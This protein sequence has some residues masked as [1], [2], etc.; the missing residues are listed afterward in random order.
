MV[1]TGSA[2]YAAEIPG[3]GT[4]TTVEYYLQATYAG[5]DW[6]GPIGAPDTV[7]AYYA[8]PDTIRPEITQVSRLPNRLSNKQ[9]YPVSAII[10]DNLGIDS[11][12]VFAHFN[13]RN[14]NVADSVLL[15]AGGEPYHFSGEL[16]P[17]FLP[18]DSV[19]Y[20]IT[21][22]DRSTAG[23]SSASPWQSFLVGHEDF[24]NGLVDWQVDSSG[25][26]LSETAY[27]GK[28]SVSTSQGGSYPPNLDAALTSKYGVDLSQ[29]NE[30]TLAFW[31]AY[32][33]EPNKDFGY[34]EI[35]TDGAATWQRLGIAFT[36]TQGAWKENSVSLSNFSG[37]G[38]NDVRLRFRFISD[39]TQAR[40]MMGWFIDDIRIIPGATSV[41]A[42]QSARPDRFALYQNYPNPFNPSTTIAFALP[43]ASFVTLKIYS[44][45]GNEVAA[46]VS[47][48]LP[49]GK[50][51]R[52]W[53]VKGLATGVYLCRLEAG[54]PSTSSG[55][56][57]VQTRKLILLR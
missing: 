19:A 51:Q 6:F 37:P 44:L 7:Y 1:E 38:F 14:I 34:I 2:H 40:P 30:A 4:P 16:P 17:I 18:G 39:S 32:F 8:G 42:A 36:G 28:Y 12:S 9:S 21:V 33:I 3:P 29:M 11:S 35:S 50:H 15:A 43:K 20:Q 22:K 26:A 56:G 47:E 24:E 53:Q 31:T 10:T 13:V 52:V 46:L 55:R 23:N 25:W 27:R 45:L 5:F 48:K 49:A 54:D 41:A 57:F